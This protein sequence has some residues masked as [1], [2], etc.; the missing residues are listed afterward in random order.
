MRPITLFIFYIRLGF[1]LQKY[2]KYVNLSSVIWLFDKF[3]S[4]KTVAKSRSCK[5]DLDFCDCVGRENLYLITIQ[6]QYLFIIE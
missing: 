5:A 3:F 6:I 1:F 4:S 2:T